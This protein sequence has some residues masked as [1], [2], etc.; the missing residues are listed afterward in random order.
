MRKNLKNPLTTDLLNNSASF[1][2]L[3]FQTTLP[4]DKSRLS[5]LTT[6]EQ[7]PS[8]KETSRSNTTLKH[9]D[10]D[11]KENLSPIQ[12][13]GEKHAKNPGNWFLKKNGKIEKNTKNLKFEK[14][15][16]NS[17][18]NSKEFLREK[19]VKN[20]RN[21]INT[22]KSSMI[23][24]K[25][26]ANF[27]K[28]TVFTEKNEGEKLENVK[29]RLEIDLRKSLFDYEKSQETSKLQRNF[30][31]KRQKAIKSE[32]ESTLASYN[33]EKTNE[34][35]QIQAKFLRN[36]SLM[37]THEKLLEIVKKM[38]FLRE[39]P[40]FR[41]FEANFSSF[42]QEKSL[43]IERI[44]EEEDQL[45]M[46]NEQKSM[47]FEDFGSKQSQIVEWAFEYE[48]LEGILEDL[49]VQ[50]PQETHEIAYEL[51]FLD[52]KAEIC[53]NLQERKKRVFSLENAKKEKELEIEKA[54]LVIEIL[55]KKLEELRNSK[56]E[57][58]NMRKALESGKSE[59][60]EEI[61]ETAKEAFSQYLSIFH[62]EIAE[63]AKKG[64]EKA[65]FEAQDLVLAEFSAFFNDE[66]KKNEISEKKRVFLE[67]SEEN[68]IITVV[69]MNEQ[70]FLNI[71]SGIKGENREKVV[72]S[73]I[74]SHFSAEKTIF[75]GFFSCLQDLQ[76]K[77]EEYRQRSE[78][79]LALQ[80]DLSFVLKDLSQEIREANFLKDSLK[81]LTILNEKELRESQAIFSAG[82]E[83]MLIDFMEN[84][85]DILKEIRFKYGKEYYRKY[86]ENLQ[87]EFKNRNKGLFEKLKE[88]IS[89]VFLQRRKLEILKKNSK[90]HLE[91]E[92]LPEIHRFSE[93]KE[94]ILERIKVLKNKMKE[95]L[96]K[97][98]AFNRNL[99]K[100]VE[101]SPEIQ[102]K[103]LIYEHRADIS[104]TCEIFLNSDEIPDK[105]TRISGFYRTKFL[106]EKAE[107]LQKELRN[108]EN[109]GFT[110]ESA[111]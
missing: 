41:V 62:A 31:E 90:K 79:L 14:N 17:F 21:A 109:E 99:E 96:H 53:D 30:L 78:N 56:Q 29:K 23:E 100:F 10:K 50:Y 81:S 38:Q 104:Q 89:Q 102:I 48:D 67:N 42:S 47:I 22:E 51:E 24:E 97:E 5:F 94:E 105:N 91:N 46:K 72:L 65:V 73:Q 1:L 92:L 76:V 2:N 32:L 57:L 45:L 8:S 93:E 101:K 37:K 88:K 40:L 39:N 49:K 6:N 36:S 70:L 59:I 64:G 68:P 33:E 4:P 28:N 80:R 86:E 34:N 27:E 82:T 7:M 69:F 9:N 3:S 98:K 58:K 55:H 60:L 110:V 16:R 12:F 63:K 61:D 103:Q 13:K 106:S 84:Q 71:S 108:L 66:G 87:K 20:V 74:S 77:S 83:E 95:L 15:T 107:N 54:R 43:L 52:K 111:E 18:Q 44:Y 75:Q 11:D 19:N 35:L 25:K 26:S 85:K